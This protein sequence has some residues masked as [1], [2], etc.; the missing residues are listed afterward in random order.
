MMIKQPDKIEIITNR[1][2]LVPPFFIPSCPPR[3]SGHIKIHGS[4]YD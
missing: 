1:G 4:A 2:G 3:V